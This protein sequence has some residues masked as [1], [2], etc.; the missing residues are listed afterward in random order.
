RQPGDGVAAVVVEL[1]ANRVGAGGERLVRGVGR[2]GLV[3]PGV[4]DL[5]AVDVDAHAVVG[6]RGKAIRAGREGVRLR[7]ARAPLVGVD[8]LPRRAGPGEVQVRAVIAGE[9]RGAAEGHVV[10]VAALPRRGGGWGRRGRAVGELRDGVAAVVVELVHQRV[11]AGRDRVVGAVA[12]RGLVL[13]GIDDLRAIDV[14]A[15]AVV[16]GRGE[17]IG[18]G[19]ERV[20]LRPAG[21]PLVAVDAAA[22]RARPCVI[23][24][25]AVVAGEDGGARERHVVVVDAGPASG[26]GVGARGGRGADRGG[27][28]EREAEGDGRRAEGDGAHAPPRGC[29]VRESAGRRTAVAAAAPAREPRGYRESQLRGPRRGGELTKR[30]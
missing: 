1:E 27:R 13:P 14:D 2:R 9:G 30:V 18:A 20:G 7:P 16:G 8:A 6:G 21:A 23:E 5:R 22:G 15:H 11:R 4:D 26:R 28:D 12:R 24:V 19:R 17:V 29:N 10:E 25:R 3:D